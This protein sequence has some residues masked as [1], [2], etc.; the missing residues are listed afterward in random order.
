[1]ISL[2]GCDRGYVSNSFFATRRRARCLLAGVALI[3]GA[4]V[5]FAVNPHAVPKPVVVASLG[6]AQRLGIAEV[7]A[8]GALLR[9]AISGI[10]ASVISALQKE[11]NPYPISRKWPISPGAIAKAG[12]ALARLATPIGV[13]LL[14]VSLL[15]DGGDAYKDPEG[16]WRKY[17]DGYVPGKYKYYVTG[18]G[19]VCDQGDKI[20]P[21]ASISL[22]HAQCKNPTLGLVSCNR[23]GTGLLAG[24]APDKFE[25]KN[26]AGAT[27]VW[28]SWGALSA[29]VSPQ[30]WNG[31]GCGEAGSAVGDPMSDQAVDDRLETKLKADPNKM[32]PAY[33]ET[34]EN[35]QADIYPPVPLS[36]WEGPAAM[37]GEHTESVETG[38]EGQ[39][40]TEQD[41][42][43][44]I[45]YQPDGSIRIVDKI[46]KTIT[47]PDGSQR[48]IIEYTDPLAQVAPDGAAPGAPV[49]LC[50]EGS[51]ISACQPLG[52]PPEVPDLPT[53][54]IS[55]GLSAVSSNGTCPAA[56]SLAVAGRN[57][58]FS[59]QPACTFA[60]GIRPIVLGI[61][62]LGA[63]LW[64]FAA[65]RGTTA[66]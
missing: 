20:W 52:T 9:D 19:G 60:T 53:R 63:G 41:T 37:P 26:A 47:Y 1:M 43:H 61:C 39:T 58:E 48:E 46:T 22:T 11:G 59:W 6:L 8:G 4:P 34:I 33:E 65:A 66:K 38:P 10:D 29:C 12:G 55:F 28:V 21:S 17:P 5:A 2:K 18:T 13:A 24:S 56:Q 3:A 64:L 32:V 54:D 57:I 44:Q 16:Q 36:P 30:I 15:N 35:G 50:V 40:L 45:F 7:A 27:Q 14:V 42:E 31:T 49:Q 23:Y 62:W 25:C 51:T